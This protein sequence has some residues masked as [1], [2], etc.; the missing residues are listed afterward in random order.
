MSEAQTPNDV[1]LKT[2]WLG[3][4]VGTV[5][6]AIGLVVGI[7]ALIQFFPRLS[8]T[9]SSP[10]DRNDPLTSSRFTVSNDGYFRVTDVMSACFL[11][12]V[13]MA[14]GG[15]TNVHIDRG[16]AEVVKPPESKLSPTEGLTVPCTGNRIV[17]SSPP[18]AQPVLAR[19]DLAIVVYYRTWPFTFYRDHRLFRFVA[20]NGMNS[21]IVWDKQPTSEVMERDF[22]GFIQMHGG[23]FPPSSPQRPLL[24]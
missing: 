22:A 18:Y 4:H 7:I 16:L 23:T 2:S 1:S 5:L 3:R 17:G 19:A 15:R 11:W 10:A 24:K 9:A 21:E 13:E 20:R 12:K 14:Q 6:T 8:A